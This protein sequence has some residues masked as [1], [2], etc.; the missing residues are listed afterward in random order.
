[1]CLQSLDDSVIKSAMNKPERLGVDDQKKANLF[2]TISLIVLIWSLAFYALAHSR[3]GSFANVGEI[4]TLLFGAASVALAVFS[5][6]IGVLAFFGWQ[7]IERQ[8]RD[9]VSASTHSIELHTNKKI[10]DLEN[11]LRGRAYST[12]GYMIGE[13]NIEPGSLIPKDR[14]RLEESVTN[15]RLG[16]ELLQKVG[17]PMEYM[18]LN[19]LVFYSCAY[20]DNSNPALLLTQAR[21]LKSAAQEHSGPGASNVLLTACR[22][23]LQYGTDPQEIKEAQDTLSR[24]ASSRLPERLKSEARLYLTISPGAP[25]T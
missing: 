6:L 21:K 22:A 13:M 20:G 2:L 1:M 15:C 19:N 17:G 4:A 14:E 7:A 11:E 12:L 18:G 9:R 25:A 16:H 3:L 8:I 10:A 5:I 24:L 23:I